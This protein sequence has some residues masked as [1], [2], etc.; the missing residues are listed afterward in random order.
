M[1]VAIVEDHALFMRLLAAL[2]TREGFTH[3]GSATNGRQGLEM[4]RETKPDVV[5]LDLQLPE[6][7]GLEIARLVKSELPF[8]RILALSAESDPYTVHRAQ[9]VGIDGYL[10]KSDQ[11]LT[12]EVTLLNAIFSVA[13]GKKVYSSKI[14]AA[15]KDNDFTKMLSEREIEVLRAITKCKSNES[16][17]SSLKLSEATV[18][19]HKRNIMNKLGIHSTPDLIA[20][21]LAKGFVKPDDFQDTSV[22]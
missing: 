9:E 19:T 2:V 21:S 5:I 18:V 8:T 11:S 22:Q 4:I 20:Y 7:H 15:A 10:D 16:V 13:Q 17:A 1:K 14:E 6:L 3:V 12:D